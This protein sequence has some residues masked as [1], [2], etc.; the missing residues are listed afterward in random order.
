MKHV[1]TL[2]PFSIFFFAFIASSHAQHANK[3]IITVG[4][5]V[6]G[7]FSF[8]DEEGYL[9]Y[10]A[11]ATVD[12]PF[13]KQFSANVG[14]NVHYGTYMPSGSPSERVM[15]NT[16][17]GVQGD[18]RFHFEERFDGWF[19]GLGA[20][21]QH[22]NAVNFFEPAPGDP[23]PTLIAWETKGVVSTGTFIKL[24]NGKY[25]NPVFRLGV[26]PG[27]EYELYSR[28]SLNFGF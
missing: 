13:S 7:T 14:G 15:R 17:L 1:S 24:K 8:W 12:F 2:L 18:I 16:L 28:F 3:P 10:G 5:S 26:G 20:E 23:T 9:A 25:I 22:L 4:P 21:T 27:N 19:F 11:S 6:Q